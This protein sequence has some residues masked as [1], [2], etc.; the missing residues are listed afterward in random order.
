MTGLDLLPKTPR[1]ALV[2]GAARQEPRLIAALTEGLGC[3]V[4]AA[5]DA[6]LPGD[7]LHA[8]AAAHL[9]VQAARGLP[10]SFPGTTGLRTAFGGASLSRPGDLA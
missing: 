6:G 7:A 3:P 1:R 5:D 4:L 9:A 10:T 2:F 8:L